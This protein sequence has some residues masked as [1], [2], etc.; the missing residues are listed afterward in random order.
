MLSLVAR[1]VPVQFHPLMADLHLKGWSIADILVMIIVIAACVGIMY[2][3]LKV[4]G[5]GIPEWAVH[6][7]WIVVVA[8]VAIVAIRFILSL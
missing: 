5:V 1:I 2:V 3:A 8:F 7:F 6:I 4:F